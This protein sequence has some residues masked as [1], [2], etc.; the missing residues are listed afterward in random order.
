MIKYNF[1][2]FKNTGVG[3]SKT[4]FKKIF[5]ILENITD[6]II[7]LCHQCKEPSNTHTNCINQACHILFIQCENCSKKYT[8]C[9]SKNCSDFI[10]LPKEE[11]KR[12][13]KKGEVK[14][15]AQKSNSI[16]PKLYKLN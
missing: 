4:C 1:N 7:S 13:F 16:K 6:D 5:S 3:L 2:Q 10:K 15:T 9:C 14:F 8:D 11:Q 12:L